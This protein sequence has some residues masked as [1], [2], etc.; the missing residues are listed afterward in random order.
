MRITLSFVAL[1]FLA[2][3]SPNL[4]PFTQDLYDQN[5][6]SESELKNIQFYLSNDIVLHR[7][8]SGGK[9]TISGGKIRMVNGRQVEEIVFKKG[10]PG[11]L[12]FTP[13]VDRFAV[14]FESEGKD[15]FLMFGPNPKAGDR[16]VLLAKDW[17]RRSGKVSYD[18]KIYSTTSHSAIAHLMVDL[19]RIQKL[20]LER[21]TAEGRKVGGQ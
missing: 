8:L 20:E 12:L 19:R 9:S 1:I 13:K 14:S 10:T 16:Y 21:R 7:E 4:A 6:W 3:C 17:D 15:R 11:V 2:G 5:R 18:G